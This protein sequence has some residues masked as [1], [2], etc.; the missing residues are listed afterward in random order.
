[1]LKSLRMLVDWRK[2]YGDDFAET[3][4]EH[5]KIN[6]KDAMQLNEARRFVSHYFQRARTLYNKGYVSK[7]FYE[8]VC[9]TSG[10]EVMLE[11]IEPLEEVISKVDV[12]QFLDRTVFDDLRKMRKARRTSQVDAVA[13]R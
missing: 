9:E 5:Y 10:I 13:F 4:R 7:R 1:M 6:E 8:T 3:F 11:I 12:G 2:V